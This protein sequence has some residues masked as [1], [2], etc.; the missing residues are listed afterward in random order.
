MLPA[1][2]LPTPV[3]GLPGA[4]TNGEA[5]HGAT[6][7]GSPVTSEGPTATVVF[8]AVRIVVFFRIESSCVHVALYLL[9]VCALFFFVFDCDVLFSA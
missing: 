8:A 3:S 9:F 7:Q 2:V 4:T 5:M 1:P 6:T